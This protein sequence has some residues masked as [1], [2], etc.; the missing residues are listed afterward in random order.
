MPVISQ[1]Q[2]H[3]VRDGESLSEG[4]AE[5]FVDA[6][7]TAIS[8]RGVAAVALCGG[9]ISRK[10]FAMLAEEPYASRLAPLWTRLHV[11]WTTERH[12]RPD[13][14]DSFF[15]LAHWTLL[16][17]FS[18]PSTNVHRIRAEM[19]DSKT[20][21]AAY[22][23]D[24]RTFFEPRGLMRDGFPCFDLTVLALDP[25]AE[26]ETVEAR[27][28]PAGRWVTT[29]TSAREQKEIMLTLPV[30]G[31]ARSALVLFGS[32]DAAAA[33]RAAHLLKFVA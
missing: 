4:A 26:R 12:V 17:R 22:Q 28:D 20:V 25:H 29:R 6:V 31:A 8:D 13:H 1:R 14:P 5:A 30:L 16:S 24:L 27:T 32:G 3:F 19:A 2:I 10:L 7:E 23:Q 15:R 9:S 11:F 33:G 18:I 21:A